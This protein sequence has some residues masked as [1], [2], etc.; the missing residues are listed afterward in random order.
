[1]G[2]EFIPRACIALP[3]I[4]PI[5]SPANSPFAVPHTVPSDGDLHP[6]ICRA[7]VTDRPM[8]VFALFLLPSSFPRAKQLA[9]AE[10]PVTTGATTPLPPPGS[11]S[12][13]LRHWRLFCHSST[14]WILNH[15]AFSG[16]HLF[17]GCF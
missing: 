10:L 15:Y 5:F 17:L 6:S 16:Y 3:I 4:L 12:T 7:P 9:L 11:E 1:M 8:A 13:G 14:E 2:G